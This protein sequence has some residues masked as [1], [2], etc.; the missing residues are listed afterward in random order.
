MQVWRG[1]RF[2]FERGP[3]LPLDLTAA[4]AAVSV[5]GTRVYVLGGR[6]NREPYLSSAFVLDLTAASLEWVELDSMP[7]ATRSAACAVVD[8][9]YG[10]EV[11]HKCLK[12]ALY[13][14]PLSDNRG[15]GQEDWQLH[16]GQRLCLQSGEQDVED[17]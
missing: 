8:G 9:T 17:A 6:G 1:A 11:S 16:L 15:R 4:C 10:E 12:T 7:G 2:E 5:N 13:T 3:D 14:T